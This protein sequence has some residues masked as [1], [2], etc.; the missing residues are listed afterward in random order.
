LKIRVSLV[1]FRPWAPFASERLAHHCPSSDDGRDFD[2]PMGR[3]EIFSG[4]AFGVRGP[5]KLTASC[6]F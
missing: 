4:A 1:R 2:F 5:C 3:F 6:S